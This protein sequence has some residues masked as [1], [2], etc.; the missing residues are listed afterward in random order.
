MQ[1]IGNHTS[2]KSANVL[3]FSNR[4]LLKGE[5]CSRKVFVAIFFLFSECGKKSISSLARVVII[6]M[7]KMHWKSKICE[8][9]VII[10]V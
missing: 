6:E 9:L 8:K 5:K 10:R 7:L 3:K 4:K 1:K 2:V